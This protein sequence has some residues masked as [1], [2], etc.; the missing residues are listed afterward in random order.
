MKRHFL[1][2]ILLAGLCMG[3]DG[4]T[5]ELPGQPSVATPEVVVPEAHILPMSE[6]TREV[7]FF[8]Q[9]GCPPCEQ[10]K[11][12]V[13]EMQKQ[14]LKVTEVDIYAQ[15]DLARQYGITQTPTFIFLEDGIEVE[16]TSDII[17][18]VTI[19]VKILAWILPLFL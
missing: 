4:V 19:L 15:P 6:L 8:T 3:C 18:L 9:P 16:R 12:R 13:E 10:A 5:I 14:G 11:P 7:L 2:I 1:L 17:L